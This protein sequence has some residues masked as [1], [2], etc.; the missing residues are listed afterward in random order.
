MEK[1]KDILRSQKQIIYRHITSK[2]KQERKN[3]YKQFLKNESELHKTYSELGSNFLRQ[4]NLDCDKH[5]KRS[6]WSDVLCIINLIV[7]NLKTTFWLCVF[8]GACFCIPYFLNINQ[9]LQTNLNNIVY[10][11][12]GVSILAFLY[13]CIIILFLMSYSYA[14]FKNNIKHKFTNFIFWIMQIYMFIILILPFIYDFKILK[15]IF[16][17][18]LNNL[19]LALCGYFLLF[20]GY[21]GFGFYKNK[22][23]KDVINWITLFFAGLFD[24]LFIEFVYTKYEGISFIWLLYAFYFF[25]FIK[26]IAFLKSFEYKIIFYF[27]MPLAVMIVPILSPYFVKIIKLANYTE[28]FTIKNEFTPKDILNLPNCFEG[29]SLT[30]IDDNLSDSNRTKINNLIVE[31]ESKDRYYFKARAENY[32]FYPNDKKRYFEKVIKNSCE[33]NNSAPCYEQNATHIT[34][35]NYEKLFSETKKERENLFVRKFKIHK[36][37]IEN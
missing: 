9:V 19:N 17:I 7:T 33:N 31:V 29:Y 30:C 24:I 20:V 34:I 4:Y 10:L 36:K 13:I 35:K 25:I 26:T 21:F 11:L 5:T 12:F 6:V 18:L 14:I 1:I 32:F 37:N 2:D 28:D 23:Y 8:F 15:K 22:N 16:D 27:A 3:L